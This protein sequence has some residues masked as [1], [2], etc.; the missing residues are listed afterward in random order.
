LEKLEISLAREETPEESSSD[1][2]QQLM[3][4]LVTLNK[5]LNLLITSQHH[6]SMEVLPWW[7]YGSWKTLLM[8][9]TMFLFFQSYEVHWLV[10]HSLVCLSLSV[11]FK[12]SREELTVAIEEISVKFSD[13]AFVSSIMA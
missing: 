13:S 6:G 2:S 9:S 10:L 7:Y 8:Q 11:F 4:C 12:G 5:S 3:T 1:A